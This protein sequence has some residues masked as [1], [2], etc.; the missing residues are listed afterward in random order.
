MHTVTCKVHLLSNFTKGTKGTTNKRLNP[1]FSDEALREGDG[2]HHD[3]A[4]AP[5]PDVPGGY[6]YP[7]QGHQYP[8]G[9]QQYPHGYHQPGKDYAPQQPY[10]PQGPPSGYYQP[11]APHTTNTSVVHVVPIAVSLFNFVYLLSCVYVTVWELFLL[12]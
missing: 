7:P 6:G 12:G 5:P 1:F 3:K 9:G 2:P 8:P 11:P 4:S 10:P